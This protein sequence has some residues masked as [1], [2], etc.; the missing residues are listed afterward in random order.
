MFVRLQMLGRS[1]GKKFGA[2]ADIVFL[3][4]QI[5]DAQRMV[6]HATSLQNKHDL[7]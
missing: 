7:D 3:K 4:A 5:F 1:V 6:R 2:R